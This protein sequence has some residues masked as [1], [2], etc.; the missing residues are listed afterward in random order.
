[1]CSQ[2]AF[3]FPV[4]QGSDE[5]WWCTSPQSIHTF[6]HRNVSSM[7]PDFFF[8][9]LH[10]MFNAP[11]NFVSLTTLSNEWANSRVNTLCVGEMHC[12]DRGS[13]GFV[14]VN[15]LLLLHVTWSH[16]SFNAEIRCGIINRYGYISPPCYNTDMY[17]MR[18]HYL[19]PHWSSTNRKTELF[20]SS[21]TIEST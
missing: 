16:C 5:M 17:L 13:C 2:V 10:R 12:R 6:K 1:M 8:F 11:I 9:F 3:W 18:W 7:L 21:N 15:V 19:T 4:V 20:Y 14:L